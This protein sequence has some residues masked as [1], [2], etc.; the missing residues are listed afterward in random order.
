MTMRNQARIGKPLPPPN[1]R[2]E[3]CYCWT[4]ALPYDHLVDDHAGR[5]QEPRVE[6][7]PPYCPTCHHV[8]PQHHQDCPRHPLN[9]LADALTATK[10]PQP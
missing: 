10:E 4:I 6:Q 8:R 2:G 9:E 1:P 3:R 5:H 7:E